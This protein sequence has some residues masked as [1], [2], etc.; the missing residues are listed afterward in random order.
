MSQ[1]EDQVFFRNFSIMLI[2]LMLV[3]ILFIVLGVIFGSIQTT[4]STEK[5]VKNTAP[6]GQ[7]QME[8]DTPPEPIVE[9]VEDSTVMAATVMADE[10]NLGKS[11]Y[12]GLCVSCHG[13]GIPGIPQLGDVAAWVDRIEQGDDILYEHAIVGYVGSASGMMMPA[14]GGNPAL[15]DEAVMAAVDYMLEQSQ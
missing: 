2:V 4:A 7:V 11:T 9:E 12:D 8:G 15:S 13:S 14:K 5:V 10:D 3:M 1:Q 6:V